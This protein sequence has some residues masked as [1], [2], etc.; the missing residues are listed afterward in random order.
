MKWGLNMNLPYYENI[1]HLSSLGVQIAFRTVPGGYSPMHW[2][3][4]LEILFSLNGNADI[5]VEG[6]KYLLKPK[7]MMVIES[8]KVHSTYT[9]TDA[10][11]FVCIHILKSRLASYMP[12]IDMYNI[13]CP[14][15]EIE[16]ERFTEY[17]EICKMLESLTRLYMTEPPTMALESEALIMLALGHLIRFFSK[18]TMPT[19]NDANLLTK[20]RL[21]EIISYVHEHYTEPI[22]LQDV[23][24]T[25]GLSREYFCRFFKQH[26]GISFLQYLMEVRLS[27]LY[28]ALTTSD[29]PISVLME[30]N[31]LYNQKLCNQA[32]KKLYGCTPSS[33]RKNPVTP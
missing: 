25:L 13:D 30:N 21:R 32:F 15:I 12:D 22:S 8:G 14:P 2:H 7:H 5:T 6:Q 23:A 9:A 20:N 18:N 4:E 31:G 28:H 29:E 10:H 24:D 17:L 16:D 33:V 1:P 26:M 3:E 27:H 11:M 19:L